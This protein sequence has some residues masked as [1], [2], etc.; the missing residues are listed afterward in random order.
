M[1]YDDGTFGAEN[2]IR[3]IIVLLPR[4]G[5]YFLSLDLVSVR[6]YIH[7]A[8]VIFLFKNNIDKWIPLE[9]IH[10]LFV[11]N[12]FFIGCFWVFVTGG[13]ILIKRI[14]MMQMHWIN[15]CWYNIWIWFYYYTYI[16]SI[17]IVFSEIL[18]L[19]KVRRF[20]LL[21]LLTNVDQNKIC[22]S[23]LY[24]YSIF[25]KPYRNKEAIK[26][27]SRHENLALLPMVKVNNPNKPLLKTNTN[28]KSLKSIFTLLMTT[29]L[30]TKTFYKRL[31]WAI[32]WIS[33]HMSCIFIDAQAS[34][35]IIC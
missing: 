11:V 13:L 12:V 7:S 28:S 5:K 16:A 32:N 26:V 14:M 27:T 4:W 25:H 2:I 20:S 34:L 10:C 6:D 1:L 19:D 17:T 33:I 22:N 24:L 3:V 18:C 31:V 9:V 29:H 21:Y 30:L 35:R 23:K 8:A 15:I